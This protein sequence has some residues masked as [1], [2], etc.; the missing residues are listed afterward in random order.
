MT[1]QRKLM[2]VF[3]HPDDESLGTGGIFAKYAAEGVATSLVMATRGERGWAGAPEE[4]PGP[5][6]LGQLR[7][8]ELHAAAQVLGIGRVS[9]LDYMDGELDQAEPAAIIAEIAAELRQVRPQVVVTF[10][11]DGGYGHP[12]HIA[13]S[14]FTTAAVLRAADPAWAKD[15]APHVVAKLYYYVTSPQSAQYWQDAGFDLRYTLDGVER[16]QIALPGWAITTFTDTTAYWRTVWQ[17]IQCH[18]SQL[19]NFQS[20]TAL[21]EETH[22]R[23][24]GYVPFYRALSLVN[25]GRAPEDDLFAGIAGAMTE[26][27][28]QPS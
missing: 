18:R 3:A 7:T 6:A 12:D 8:A 13:I 1:E 4:D 9:F 21:P 23:L 17:A 15:A 25:G 11:P 14:Q 2:G 24:W 10:G 5:A 20:L 27:F 16:R 26:S 19:P 28:P 22:R